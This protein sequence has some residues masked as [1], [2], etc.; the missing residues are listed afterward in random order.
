MLYTIFVIFLQ[1]NP[2]NVLIWCADGVW[3]G[4]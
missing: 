4:A 1:K 2:V 3:V